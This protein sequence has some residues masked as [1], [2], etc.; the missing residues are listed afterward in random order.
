VS[1]GLTGIPAGVPLNFFEKR[2]LL[3]PQAVFAKKYKTF[4]PYRDARQ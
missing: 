2:R 3:S 4:H 1:W